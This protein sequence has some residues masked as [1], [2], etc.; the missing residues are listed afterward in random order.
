[1]QSLRLQREQQVYP[2]SKVQYKPHLPPPPAS[3]CSSS[4]WVTMT[5]VQVGSTRAS[6]QSNTCGVR[7]RKEGPDAGQGRLASG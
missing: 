7:G 3:S 5:A 4:A 1:M 2:N 6:I